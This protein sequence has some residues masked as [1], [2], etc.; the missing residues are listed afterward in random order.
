MASL[1]AI[2]STQHPGGL[3]DTGNLVDTTGNAPGN[4]ASGTWVRVAEALSGP[5]WGTQFT[6]RIGGE[7]LVDFTE[8]DPDRP[9][10]V[11]QLYNGADSPP[12]SAGVDAGTNHAGVLSGWHS[13]GFDGVGFNQWQVDDSTAQLRKRVAR[14]SKANFVAINCGAF[15]ESL[16]ESELLAMNAARL[17]GHIKVR[18]A[19][20]KSRTAERFFSM[21]LATCRCRCKSNFYACC[22][23]VK[24][25]G[26]EDARHCRSMC[27]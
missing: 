16:V 10:I 9:V 26:L 25:C 13:T 23:N 1:E 14:R 12:W 7:V 15:S 20:S 22:R 6:P 5:N 24:W 8:G 18:H 3:T 19:G 11:A 4:D 27:D 21:K 2:L 17:P